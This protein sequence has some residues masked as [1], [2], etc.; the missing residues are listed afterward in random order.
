MSFVALLNDL[1]STAIEIVDDLAPEITFTRRGT[2]TYVDGVVTN[3]DTNYTVNAVLA[4]FRADEVDDK[5]NTVTDMKC[6]IA[7]ADLAVSPE[8]QDRL[9]DNTGV[10]W[11]V[12]RVMSPPGK[13]LWKLQV[14]K[15]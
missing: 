14:R 4:R 12:E 6:L 9:T 2:P 8:V 7:A 15:A 3:N 10:V 11:C 1:V 5:I 13:P